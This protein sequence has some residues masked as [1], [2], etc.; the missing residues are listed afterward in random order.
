MNTYPITDTNKNHELQCTKTTLHNNNYPTYKRKKTQ[1]KLY[2]TEHT[3]KTP[4]H[5]LEKI[6][7]SSQDYLK[8]Q[9]YEHFS[10]TRTQ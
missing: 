10:K 6:Q 9:T 4:S 7:Q 3:K 2:I 8:T 1:T 5:V